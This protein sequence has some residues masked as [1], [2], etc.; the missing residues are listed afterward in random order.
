M[1]Q[2]CCEAVETRGPEQAAVLLEQSLMNH[3]DRAERDAGCRHC[4]PVDNLAIAFIAFSVFSTRTSNSFMATS[5][6]YSYN[7][8]RTP[9]LA[10]RPHAVYRT[11]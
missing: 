6:F 2:Y 1:R 3:N 10:S 5:K 11:L 8:M 4:S 9:L 7:A